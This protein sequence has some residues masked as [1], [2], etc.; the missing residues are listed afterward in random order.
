[1]NG[2]VGAKHT[3]SGSKL[4][5]TKRNHVLADVASDKLAM[6]RVRV[7]QDVLNQVVAILI[8]SNIN[9]RD[10]GTIKAALTDPVEIATEEIGPANLE[11]LFNYFGSKLIHTVLR[12]VTDD[13]VDSTAAVTRGAMFT[14]MLN[15]PITELTMGNNINTRKDLFNTGALR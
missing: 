5:T 11:A 10:A 3:N 15:A 6:L 1:L 7:S 12:S 13:M 2:R 8:T 14:D 4:R 9:Q